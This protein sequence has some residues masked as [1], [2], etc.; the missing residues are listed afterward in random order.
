MGKVVGFQEESGNPIVAFN[1][2]DGIVEEKEI[3]DEIFTI[4]DGSSTV[5]QRIQVPL[6]LAWAISIHKSQ[7]QT[8]DR[9][10]VDLGKIFEVGQAYVAISRCTSMRTIQVWKYIHMYILSMW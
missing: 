3:G 5:A 8:L 6:I 2:K 7:G 9:L 1:L 10:I 4:T